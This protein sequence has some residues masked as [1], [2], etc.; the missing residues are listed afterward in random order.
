[1]QKVDYIDADEKLLDT[2]D[3]TVSFGW[4]GIEKKKNYTN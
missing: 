1:V 2:I 3:I 4:K